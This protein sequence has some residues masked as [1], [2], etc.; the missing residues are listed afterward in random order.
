MTIFFDYAQKVWT[1]H[2]SR[3]IDSLMH[4]NLYVCMP[5][6]CPNILSDNDSILT[7]ELIVSLNISN[8]SI[9]RT[10][11][12]DFLMHLTNANIIFYILVFCFKLHV[13]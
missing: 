1:G 13:F 7:N 5:A 2:I 10:E 12:Y 4:N 8:Y 6:I 3:T 9:G 11:L